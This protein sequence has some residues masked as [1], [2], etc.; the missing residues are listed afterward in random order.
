MN[1][2]NLYFI[3]SMVCLLISLQVGGQNLFFKD[4]GQNK[5][6]RKSQQRV[7]KPVKYRSLKIDVVQFKKYIHTIP[8]EEKLENRNNAPVLTLIKPDGKRVSFR[9]WQSRVQEQ[10]TNEAHNRVYTFTGQGIDDPYAVIRIDF[11]PGGFHAQV[12]TVNGDWFI[13]PYTPREKKFYISYYRAD[14]PP[15]EPRQPDGVENPPGNVKPVRS[16]PEPPASSGNN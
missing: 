5:K 9:I 1:K 2:G 4:A 8:T 16:S 3:F 13:D 6:F 7:I 15:R 12:L 11:G 10:T 14:L